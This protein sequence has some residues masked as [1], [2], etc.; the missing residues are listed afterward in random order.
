MLILQRKAGE[1]LFIGDD[2]EITVTSIDS[3]RVRLAIQAPREMQILRS[4]LRGA[5]SA[6][7]D[8]A[9]EVDSPD[10]LL[11]FLEHIKMHDDEENV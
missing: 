8:A 9:Q 7:L 10:A 6:N 11:S 1:S 4:E 5:M 3:S 2:I